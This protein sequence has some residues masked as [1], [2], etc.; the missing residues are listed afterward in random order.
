MLCIL[1]AVEIKLI[2]INTQ[3]HSM[4]TRELKFEKIKSRYAWIEFKVEL[5]KTMFLI[6]LLLLAMLLLL[7]W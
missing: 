5:K 4:H 6:E 1:V 2:D 7:L 3:T